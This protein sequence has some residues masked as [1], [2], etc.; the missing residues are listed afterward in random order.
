MVLC[1]FTNSLVVASR[2]EQWRA[3]GQIRSVVDTFVDRL[4]LEQVIVSDLFLLVLLLHT[5]AILTVT[6]FFCFTLQVTSLE[7]TPTQRYL[8]NVR[9]P[10]QRYTFRAPTLEAKLSWLE[11]MSSTMIQAG[12]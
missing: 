12:L 5:V 4:P 6:P 3:F 10:K 9:T 1:L 8:F 7:D 11:N 2:Q